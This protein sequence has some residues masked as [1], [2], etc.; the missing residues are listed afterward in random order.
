MTIL[1][2]TLT[3]WLLM[4]PLGNLPVF[5]SV[6]GEVAPARRRFVLVRELF[7]ALAF[8]LGFL[9]LGKYLFSLLELE[10]ASV[11]IAGGVILGTIAFR[12][13]CVCSDNRFTQRTF[14]I[15]V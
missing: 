4:D 14:S 7:L 2:A 11:R 12:M 6:L 3:L 15:G 8:L 5:S 1:S 13:L 9:F 10:T